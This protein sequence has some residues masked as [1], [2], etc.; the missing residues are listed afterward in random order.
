MAYEE[1][2]G[3]RTA[4]ILGCR[5]RKIRLASLARLGRQVGWRVGDIVYLLRKRAT[6][7]RQ[8]EYCKHPSSGLVD[9]STASTSGRGK[10]DTDRAQRVSISAVE[11]LNLASRRPVATCSPHLSRF[12]FLD[13]L[14]VFIRILVFGLSRRCTAARHRSGG[15]GECR[16]RERSR[17]GRVGA[18]KSPSRIQF[19]FNHHIPRKRAT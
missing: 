7:G 4:L 10:P 9:G 14:V 18:C 12:E 17:G 15:R 1:G 11:H 19:P 3:E 13:F 2:T 5:D 16:R 6:L 8:R